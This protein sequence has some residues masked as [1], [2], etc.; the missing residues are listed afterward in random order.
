MCLKKKA[1]ESQKDI[2]VIKLE[3]CLY[4]GT[5]ASQVAKRP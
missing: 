4:V 1:S 3:W 2:H 5:M